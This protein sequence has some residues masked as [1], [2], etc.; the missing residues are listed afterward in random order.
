MSGYKGIMFLNFQWVWVI[1]SGIK[2]LAG[3]A[4][5]HEVGKEMKDDDTLRK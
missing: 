5:T 2:K 1:D 3:K 4:K